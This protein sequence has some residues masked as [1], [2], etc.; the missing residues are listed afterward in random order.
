MALQ[1]ADSLV[2]ATAALK[3]YPDAT[4]AVRREAEPQEL[5]FRGPRHRAFRCVDLQV[6]DLLEEDPDPTHHPVTRRA[7]ANVD[8]AVVSV[9]AK[10]QPTLFEFP[11]QIREQDV[12]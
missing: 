4:V 1:V 12:G 7:T 3:R 10:R 2:Q 5:P 9:P 11:I 6:Q 8:V